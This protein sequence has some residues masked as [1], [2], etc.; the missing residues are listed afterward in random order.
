MEELEK[1]QINCPRC[2]KSPLFLVLKHKH[3]FAVDKV[4][5]TDIIPGEK[6]D[7]EAIEYL[8][9]FNCNWSGWVEEYNQCKHGIVP[10]FIS[11]E[12]D[13]TE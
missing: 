12:E 3:V 6:V 2:N 13:E 1:N 7:G 4:G 5:L 11:E 8:K 9:C 10:L